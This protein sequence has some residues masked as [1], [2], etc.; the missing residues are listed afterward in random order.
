M[1]NQILA[2]RI[3]EM[4]EERRAFRAL[5]AAEKLARANEFPNPGQKNGGRS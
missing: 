1:C 3:V 2:V 5:P 4:A